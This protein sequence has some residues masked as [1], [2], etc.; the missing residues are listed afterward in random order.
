MVGR[1]P[2][3]AFVIS[4]AWQAS[5]SFILEDLGD[6]DRTEGVAL[7]GQ[8]T[9]DVVDG[10]VLLAQGDD[11]DRGGDRLWVRTGVPWQV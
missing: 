3:W 7:V 2:G 8:I 4:P 9:A 11:A 10:E 5:E 6:G 1:E